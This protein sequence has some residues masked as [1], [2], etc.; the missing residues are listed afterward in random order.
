MKKIIPNLFFFFISAPILSPYIFGITMYVYAF[1]IFLDFAFLNWCIKVFNS[2]KILEIT[3]I[4][5]LCLVFSLKIVLILKIL[6]LLFSVIYVV[7][8][9][10]KNY[11]RYLYFWV[12]VNIVIALAQFFFVFVNPEIAYLIGPTN[13]ANLTLGNFAGP[14][15][16]NF[17]AISILPRVSGL[18]REGGFFASFL[19]VMAFIVYFDNRLSI[20]QRNWL[21]VVIF[22]GLLVCLSKTTLLILAIPLILLYRGVFNKIGVLGSV[23]LVIFIFTSVTLYLFNYTN[24]FFNESNETFIHRF[25]GYALI[26]FVE[27]QDLFLG[28]NLNELIGR[29]G[30]KMATIG[31]RFS[32]E[33]VGYELCG[34]PG[35]YLQYGVIIFSL[36][37]SLIWRLGF[38]GS[39]IIVLLF[40][41]INLTPIASTG[42]VVLAWFFCYQVI[43]K[44]KLSRNH[45]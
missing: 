1:I 9:Y 25:A 31:A 37:V 17:Y 5:L 14:S 6:M 2:R 15:N 16:T 8:S 30:I 42:F 24:F 7:Y 23:A 12:I 13:I 18:S 22:I 45:T 4:L 44:D 40:L 29:A 32:E 43:S 21:I 34:L 26:Q 19:G 39:S 20:K 10:E 36:F 41:T 11:F 33:D 28:V 38:K 35:I 3:V 27:F